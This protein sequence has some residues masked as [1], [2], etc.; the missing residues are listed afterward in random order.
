M[1]ED[2]RKQSFIPG[3]ITKIVQHK[4]VYVQNIYLTQICV[5]VSNNFNDFEVIQK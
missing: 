4:E 1:M 2:S 5:T 3:N